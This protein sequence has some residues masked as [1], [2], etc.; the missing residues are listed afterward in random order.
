MKAVGHGD[1][2]ASCLHPVSLGVSLLPG[3]HEVISF[4]PSLFSSKMVCCVTDPYLLLDNY[5]LYP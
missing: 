1:M 4:N 3:C 2:A 5:G